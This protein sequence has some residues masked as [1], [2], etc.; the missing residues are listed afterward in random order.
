MRFGLTALKVSGVVDQ[1]DI[2]AHA[3]P[4]KETS[5]EEIKRLKALV[6]TRKAEYRKSEKLTIKAATEKAMNSLT[7]AQ[8]R[9]VETSTHGKR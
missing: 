2:F 5:K 6:N 4:C 7:P 3:I 1:R 9:L 8:R